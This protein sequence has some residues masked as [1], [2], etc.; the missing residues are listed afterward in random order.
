MMDGV[1]RHRIGG[2]FPEEVKSPRIRE[3]LQV[4]A[5]EWILTE[6]PV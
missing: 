3:D 1:V 5:V 2:T 4:I 6:A